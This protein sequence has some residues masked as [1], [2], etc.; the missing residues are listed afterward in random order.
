MSVSLQNSY[1]KSV[2]PNVMVFEGGAFEGGEII[3]V[4]LGHGSGTLIP[5]DG[6]N[7]L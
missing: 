7:T 4:R 5:H 1:V 2:L 3:R 6:I